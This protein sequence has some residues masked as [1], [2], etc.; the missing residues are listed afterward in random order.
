MAGFD[1]RISVAPMMDWTDEVYFGL[2][3]SDLAESKNACRLYVASKKW[4]PQPAVAKRVWL[5]LAATRIGIL[6]G[7]SMG[8]HPETR[9]GC[10]AIEK[11]REAS[12]AR[13]RI[14]HE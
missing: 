5:G 8:F 10:R 13:V 6:V 7:V 1:R 12:T 2:L 4:G 9:T 14:C 3:L 11:S